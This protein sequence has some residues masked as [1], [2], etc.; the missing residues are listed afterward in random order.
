MRR[1]LNVVVL[2]RHWKSVESLLQKKILVVFLKY[3]K[4]ANFPV[5]MII[6]ILRSGNRARG[7]AKITAECYAAINVEIM[8]H[9]LIHAMD[10]A[11]LVRIRRMGVSPHV[12][13]CTAVAC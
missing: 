5:A 2:R 9:V 13:R 6:V 12:R 1:W 4:S 7:I 8:K 3:M 10:Y 11:Y